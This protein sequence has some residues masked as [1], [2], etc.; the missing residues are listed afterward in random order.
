MTPRLPVARFRTDWLRVVTDLRE[1]GYS[2]A[3][4]AKRAAIS[5]P[6]LRSWKEGHEPLHDAGHRLLEIWVKVT[7]KAYND[8]PMTVA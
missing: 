6:S 4:I 7:G 5:E 2:Q 3:E 8:R 1:K